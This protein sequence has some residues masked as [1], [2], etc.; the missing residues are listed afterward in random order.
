[1]KITPDNAVG[2]LG[3]VFDLG[4]KIYGVINTGD[5]ADATEEIARLDAARMKGSEEV[6]E[7]H[8]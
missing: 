8:A 2:L 7:G 5:P 1:M 3:L 4:V 6:L